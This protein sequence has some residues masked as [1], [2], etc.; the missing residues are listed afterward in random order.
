[1]QRAE[2]ARNLKP[3]K[4]VYVGIEPL[5]PSTKQANVGRSS[6]MLLL[7]HTFCLRS[8]MRFAIFALAMMLSSAAESAKIY[9]PS[10]RLKTPDN[11]LAAVEI[12]EV[13]DDALR[14][15]IRDILHASQDYQAVDAPDRWL[16][17]GPDARKFGVGQKLL[18]GF[19]QLSRDQSDPNR[20]A[21]RDKSGARL[22][23]EPGIS[24]AALP[25]TPQVR[26]F[27]A[28]EGGAKQKA[29]SDKSLEIL[30]N[31]LQAHD[32]QLAQLAVAELLLRT[33]I[34][35]VPLRARILTLASAPDAPVYLREMAMIRAWHQT[36]GFTRAEAIKLALTNLKMLD[37][38]N[39]Q[40]AGVAN[41]ALELVHDRNT[42]PCWKKPFWSCVCATQNA[43]RLRLAN[44][45]QA[46]SCRPISAIF[47]R[48]H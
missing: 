45:P 11:T 21:I 34:L 5:G 18:L 43:L 40:H 29:L 1:M 23:S 7:H 2:Y 14:V 32:P 33:Q 13:T 19:T 38:R 3:G 46:R 36:Q 6:K 35:P 25:D 44:T 10:A 37:V 48:E 12:L 30:S 4:P 39:P 27:F 8:I 24:P 28:S 41:T 42:A 22:I 20:T 31:W 17:A 9:P 16:R 47:F 15:K 26:A